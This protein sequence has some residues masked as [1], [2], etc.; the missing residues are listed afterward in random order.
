VTQKFHQETS[1]ADKNFQQS[2][3][4]IKLTNKNQMGGKQHLLK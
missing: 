2:D 4:N 1:T 3:W